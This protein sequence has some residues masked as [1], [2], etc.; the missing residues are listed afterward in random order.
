MG[1]DKDCDL[2]SCF[3]CTHCSPIWRELIALKK[4]TI[5]YKKGKSVFNEGEKAKG[6][7]FVYSGSVKVSM[8]WLGKKEMIIRFAKSGGVIGHRGLGAS[9]VYPVSAITL[10]DSEV[11]FIGNDFF[12]TTLLNNPSLSYQFMHLYANELQRAELRM[13]DLA[14]MEVKGRIA[15]T[16]LELADTFGTGKNKYITVPV[17]RQDIAA[18]SGTTYETVFKILRTLIDNKTISSS[19]KSIRIN[20][21][22]KLKSIVKNAK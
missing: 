9:K 3:L 4:T 10:E 8:E 7:Y 21:M 22:T 5:F 2:S 14:L 18:Y 20:D 19:G 1:R 17:S 11:C 16:L 13:R 6:I 12:D 15:A